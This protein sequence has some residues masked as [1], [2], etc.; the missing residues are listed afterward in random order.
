M[1][2]WPKIEKKHFT[3]SSRWIKFIQNAKDIKPQK[4][5]ENYVINWTQKP[6]DNLIAIK[7]TSRKFYPQYFEVKL[8]NTGEYIFLFGARKE[9]LFSDFSSTVFFM[10]VSFLLVFT[11]YLLIL[12]FI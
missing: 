4:P 5:V 11:F 1:M 3:K 2:S 9:T 8:N 7:K 12:C 10:G 6:K